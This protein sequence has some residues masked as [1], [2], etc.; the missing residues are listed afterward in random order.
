MLARIV[1]CAI[2]LILAVRMGSVDVA[3]D[4]VSGPSSRSAT[5]L[6]ESDTAEVGFGP[7]VKFWV[8]LMASCCDLKLHR[9][10]AHV[11]SEF[12]GVNALD[13]AYRRVLPYR[14]RV[15]SIG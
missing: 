8:A 4:H 10:D 14:R 7:P 3:A 2:N 6:P 1:S 5:P 9:I 13:P 12:E 11:V 15:E